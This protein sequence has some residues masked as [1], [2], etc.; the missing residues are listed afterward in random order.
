MPRGDTILRGAFFEVLLSNSIPAIFDGDYFKYT[1]FSDILDY[2]NFIF[3]IPEF[4]ALSDLADP[5]VSGINI[6]STLA[7]KYSSVNAMT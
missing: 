5:K 2:N 4:G 7:E 6:V 3:T 1:P